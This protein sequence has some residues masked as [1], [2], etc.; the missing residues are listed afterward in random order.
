MLSRGPL[1][2][3]GMIAFGLGVV[4]LLLP[5]IPSVPFFIAAAACFARAHRPLH[6]WMLRQRFLG[7]A[8]HDWYRHRALPYWMKVFLIVATLVSFTFSIVLFA[9]PA[10]LKLTLA[11]VALGIVSC[12]WRIPARPPRTS[13]VA[14]DDL[15]LNEPPD[16]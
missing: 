4:G 13:V 8:L 2:V 7:P 6:D 10:W 12:L 11:A 15:P 5:L 3:L 9:R 1:L 14:R 16:H